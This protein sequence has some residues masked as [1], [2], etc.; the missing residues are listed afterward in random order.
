M[1]Q[2]TGI[3]PAARDLRVCPWRRHA[4]ALGKVG[5]DESLYDYVYAFNGFAASMTEEQAT[6]LA[7]AKNVLA[8][9]PD[10]A[11]PIE[12]STTP[13]FLGLSGPNGLWQQTVGE[14]VVIGMLDTGFWP[15]NP[16]YSDRT[17]DNPQG[18]SGKLGYQQIPGRPPA[19]RP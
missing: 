12:T 14:D 4:A 17:G 15:E 3:A 6:K 7:T 18:K 2:R 11:D 1:F 9:T 8:V 5:A 19:R 13:A 16:T 10:R